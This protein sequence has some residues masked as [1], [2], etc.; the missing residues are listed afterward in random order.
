M[1][2]RLTAGKPEVFEK[3]FILKSVAN[4]LSLSGCYK[5]GGAMFV[6]ICKVAGRFRLVFSEVTMEE[7]KTRNFV[8][9]IRGWMRPKKPVDTFLEELSKAGATHHSILV[10]GAKPD[11][12]RFFAE[13]LDLDIVEI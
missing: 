13:L 6:N 1:N 5:S 3:S 7:E 4:P 11:Q 2:I 9:N 10:Y 12:I 8:G